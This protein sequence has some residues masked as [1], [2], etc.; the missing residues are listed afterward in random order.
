VQS[1]VTRCLP[2][3]FHQVDRILRYRQRK[4]ADIWGTVSYEQEVTCFRL[5]FSNRV[6]SNSDLSALQI[7]KTRRGLRT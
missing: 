5:D 7:R 2:A 4:S 3:R 6:H 1:A